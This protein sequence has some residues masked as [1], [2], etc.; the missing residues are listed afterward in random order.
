MSQNPLNCAVIRV[1]DELIEFSLYTGLGRPS[2]GDN[3]GRFGL[4]GFLTYPTA[5][6][7]ILVRRENVSL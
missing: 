1:L 2:V 7:K 6:T 5:A 3:R 4:S